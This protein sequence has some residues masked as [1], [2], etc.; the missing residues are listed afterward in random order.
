MGEEA[1]GV[2]R[3][4]GAQRDPTGQA[5][6]SAWGRGGDGG[7]VMELLN[8]VHRLLAVFMHPKEGGSRGQGHGRASSKARSFFAPAHSRHHPRSRSHR[9]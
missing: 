9:W 2:F 1:K 6:T 8:P 4:L 5:E 3:A 7:R